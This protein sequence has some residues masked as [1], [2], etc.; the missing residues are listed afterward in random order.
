MMECKR[1]H[2][3][4]LAKEV[5]KLCLKNWLENLKQKKRVHALNYVLTTRTWIESF[6]G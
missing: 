1:K 4:D 2:A 5:I 3:T 6:K